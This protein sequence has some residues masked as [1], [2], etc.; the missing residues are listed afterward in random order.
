IGL[1]GD[2]DR[3]NHQDRQEEEQQE[4]PDDSHHQAVAGGRAHFEFPPNAARIAGLRMASAS[5][6][7]TMISKAAESAVARSHRP[8]FE[9]WTEIYSAIISVRPPPSRA[10][11]M[12]KPSEKT[13]M[14]SVA[15]AM[16]G[17]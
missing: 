11:V 15:T 17:R 3:D 8:V 6:R 13:R 1:V 14:K 2:R 5:S 9:I 12:R 4:E 10:G 7:P 16:P